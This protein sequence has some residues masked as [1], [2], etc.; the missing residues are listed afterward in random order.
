MQVDDPPSQVMF[1]MPESPMGK[2]MF[3]ET[4]GELKIQSVL[5]LANNYDLLI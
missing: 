2:A 4:F 3:V 1:N 5:L